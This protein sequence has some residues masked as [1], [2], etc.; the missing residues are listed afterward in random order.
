ME[1]ILIAH[2]CDKR[3][4]VTIEGTFFLKTKKEISAFCKKY[5]FK[6]LDLNS[7]EISIFVRKEKG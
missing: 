7:N 2:K 4:R 3:W 6:I 5:G 1:K